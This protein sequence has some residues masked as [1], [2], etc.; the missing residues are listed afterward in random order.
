MM[1]KGGRHQ[2][3]IGHL[4]DESFQSITCRPEQPREKGR[5]HA[6]LK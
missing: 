6:N 1:Y 2:Q 3:I 5:T 4:G